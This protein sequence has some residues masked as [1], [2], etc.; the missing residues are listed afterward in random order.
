MAQCLRDARGEISPCSAARVTSSGSWQW[1]LPVSAAGIARRTPRPH[2]HPPAVL[3]S[4]LQHKH[5][6]LQHATGIKPHQPTRII[7]LMPPGPASKPHPYTAAPCS[8][9]T[10]TSKVTWR[11]WSNT[12]H[13]L[14]CFLGTLQFQQANIALLVHWYFIFTYPSAHICTLDHMFTVLLHKSLSQQCWIVMRGYFW[15][16]ALNQHHLHKLQSHQ[17]KSAIS[18][19]ALILSNPKKRIHTA[20]VHRQTWTSSSHTNWN[21]HIKYML[22][23]TSKIF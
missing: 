14:S 16:T 3:S 23:L 12:N 13:R 7:Q 10:T 17:F 2:W 21:W 8:P 6:A 1:W 5:E 18:W 4:H 11:P 9:S 19:L 22:T 15:N 20:A